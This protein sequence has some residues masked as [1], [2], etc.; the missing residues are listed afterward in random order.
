MTD[1]PAIAKARG[2]HASAKELEGMAEVLAAL[3]RAF[4]PLAREI[5]L[6]TEP[7]AVFRAS[8]E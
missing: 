5:P 7:A 1:W 8:V 4:A 2:V 3:E 6:D